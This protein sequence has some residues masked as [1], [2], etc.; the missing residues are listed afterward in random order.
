MFTQLVIDHLIFKFLPQCH[1]DKVFKLATSISI[2]A[3]TTESPILTISPSSACCT[4]ETA[5]S[6]ASNTPIT[7]LTIA[8]T[9]SV[10]ATVTTACVIAASLTVGWNWSI[11]IGHRPIVWTRFVPLLRSAIVV[12]ISAATGSP[13]SS[14]DTCAAM[15]THSAGAPMASPSA[16]ATIYAGSIL[17]VDASTIVAATL[18]VTTYPVCSTCA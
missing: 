13:H 2:S 3:G 18:I 7:S 17:A 11:V 14:V 9:V 15:S 1:R 12:I 8:A 6:S 5:A 4:I 10:G 16:D